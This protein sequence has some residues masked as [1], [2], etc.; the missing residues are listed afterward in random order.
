MMIKLRQKKTGEIEIKKC[1]IPMR[2]KGVEGI[3]GVKK[4]L[5]IFLPIW[6]LLQ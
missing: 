1:G 5:P 2:R 4:D 6:D 3:K